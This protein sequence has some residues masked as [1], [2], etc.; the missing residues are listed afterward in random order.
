MRN[1][2]YSVQSIIG[3]EL[4]ERSFDHSGGVSQKRKV[5]RPAGRCHALKSSMF[6]FQ[7]TLF[8]LSPRPIHPA[9][10]VLP[11]EI[12]SSQT[13]FFASEYMNCTAVMP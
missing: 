6:T 5:S 12:V 9:R 2:G 8:H 7:Q 1:T 4:N 13:H 3:P 11:L 10:H